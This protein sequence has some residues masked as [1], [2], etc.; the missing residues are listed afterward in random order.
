MDNG[1]GAK[2]F[3]WK[4][5]WCNISFIMTFR[6]DSVFISNYLYLYSY[7]CLS[8][9]CGHYDDNATTDDDDTDADDDH[10]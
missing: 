7:I 6:Q 1:Q 4:S 9:N 3:D 2:T 8:W 10:D 5:G